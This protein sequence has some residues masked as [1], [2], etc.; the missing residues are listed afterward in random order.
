MRIPQKFHSNKKRSGMRWRTGSVVL[1][2][3]TVLNFCAFTAK[4]AEGVSPGDSSVSSSKSE[5]KTESKTE[6]K[7]EAKSGGKPELQNRFAYKPVRREFWAEVEKS[8]AAKKPEEILRLSGPG[9]DKGA[10]RNEW[11]LAIAK[12]LLELGQ[13]IHAQYVLNQLASQGVGTRQGFEALRLTHEIAKAALIDE[14]QFEELAFDLD[15]KID[16]PESRSMVAFFR[17]KGLWRKGYN[18]W[19]IST[20]MDV[21][22]GSTW[23]IELNFERAQQLLAA[24]DASS[25]YAKFEAIANDPNSRRSTAGLSRLALARLIFERKDFKS[26]IATY[27]TIQL[28]SREKA[29]SLNELAWSYYYER[30]YGK[31]LGTIRSLKSSYYNVLLSPETYILEM[32]IYR[33][34]CHFPMVKSLAAEFASRYQK[35]YGAIENRQDLEALPQFVQMALQDGGLQRKANAIQQVRAE[36]GPLKKQTWADQAFKAWLVGYAQKRE[37]IADAE[38]TRILRAR[39]DSIGNWFLDLREQVWFLDYE[40]SMRMIQLNDENNN[41]YEPPQP[42]SISPDQMFWPINDEA[43]LDELLDYEV[44]IKDAC[45]AS[46]PPMMNLERLAPASGGGAR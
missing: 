37:R 20:L 2:S 15:T 3:A 44:L 45:R 16:E 42:K 25:A 46:G 33:E 7:G 13:P 21:G 28:S 23:E 40:A 30:A 32:L 31:A 27:K 38:I 14:V 19:A 10:E 6:V 35:I 41:A 24:G 11:K 39:S 18:P 22:T 12:A 4:A 26:A 1:V 8:I 29:R 36:R 5:T 43:W 9:E 17:A 34:L